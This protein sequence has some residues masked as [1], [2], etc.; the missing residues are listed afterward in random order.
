MSSTLCAD[1][2]IEQASR[3]YSLPAVALEVLRLTDD[4]TVDTLTLKNALVHDP[5]LTSKVLR[6]INSPL[7]GLQQPVSSL[8]DAV[9]LLGIKPLK[10]LVLGF[11]LPPRL[12]G[13]VENQ[14]LAGYWRRAL[15][16]A[17][18][19]R[20]IAAARAP[21]ISEDAFLAG[22]LADIGMLA[23]AQSLGR[24][25]AEVVAR[26]RAAGRSL[27]DVERHT[28]GFDH[29]QLTVHVLARWG[30]PSALVDSIS[31][32]A[33]SPQPDDPPAEPSPA[34]PLSTIL[35]LA[36]L[37]TALLVEEQLHLLPSLLAEA[38][39]AGVFSALEVTAF[40]SSLEVKVGQLAGALGLVKA[41]DLDF[42]TMLAEAQSRLADITPDAAAALAVLES[43]SR[44]DVQQA[45]GWREAQVLAEIAQRV[46][47]GTMRLAERAS[48]QH[49]A[50]VEAA[51]PAQRGAIESDL[52][53]AT[54]AGPLLERM[55]AAVTVCRQARAPLSLLLVRADPPRPQLMPGV[56]QPAYLAALAQ[57]CSQLDYPRKLCLRLNE[58]CHSVLLLQCDRVQLVGLAQDLLRRIRS[59]NPPGRSPIFSISIGAAAAPVLSA[60]FSAQRLF[61]GAY[62]CLYAAADSGNALKSIEI[63]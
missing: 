39:A 7:F 43:R 57:Q 33:E 56:D 50:T 6:A 63:Y 5:S 29:L 2:F 17:M 34:L 32:A 60:N 47:G 26:V 19:A 24:P 54:A 16:K 36:E 15:T 25:Y 8:G 45:S 46:R 37:I 18:A 42:E 41:A 55:T 28:L 3:L 51:E 31:A 35:R 10:L 59:L 12:T 22:L 13:K 61:E 30:L 4:P 53:P 1:Q 48:A 14:F 62:R 40:V 23:L 52:L 38:H 58:R 49:A 20:E 11:S 27:T 9:T 21:A 44:S